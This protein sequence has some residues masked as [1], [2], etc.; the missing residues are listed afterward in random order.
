MIGVQTHNYALICVEYDAIKEKQ[1]LQNLMT[2]GSDL[3]PEATAAHTP[4][5]ELEEVEERDRFDEGIYL[6]SSQDY[7]RRVAM[8][9]VMWCNVVVQEIEE[10]RQFL[11][12]M[13]AL[14]Q[15]KEHRNKIM[16]E[17]SQV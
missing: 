6:Y 12:E 5:E 17:I 15:G 14:G 9:S 7:V 2:Y 1:R 4:S 8:D 3:E 11:S 16:I 13:E 10:R